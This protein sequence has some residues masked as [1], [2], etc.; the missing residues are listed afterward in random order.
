MSETGS[1]P[2]S[3]GHDLKRAV[4]AYEAAQSLAQAGG[5]TGGRPNSY[6][7][8]AAPL[9][10]QEISR[11]G[12]FPSV[13]GDQAVLIVNNHRFS[14]L[15]DLLDAHMNLIKPP[16]GKD[17]TEID[18]QGIVDEVGGERRVI[19]PMTAAYEVRDTLA[20]CG[21]TVILYANVM[22]LRPDEYMFEDGAGSWLA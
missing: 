13:T 22:Q 20:V 8:L 5:P 7:R 14:G 3:S 12:I 18:Y 19:P 10:S 11:I 17:Y 15:H 2:A 9:G 21:L 16:S 1:N 4:A 6:M